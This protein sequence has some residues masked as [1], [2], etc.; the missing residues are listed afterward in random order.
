[1][2]KEQALAGVRLILLGIGSTLVHKGL[3]KDSTVQEAVGLIIDLIP[4]VWTF[5]A[6]RDPALAKKAVAIV[7]EMPNIVGDAGAS[8]VRIIP[9]VVTDPVNPPPVR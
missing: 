8:N 5:W 7:N 9:P 4:V 6:K 1:M 3:A 2:N